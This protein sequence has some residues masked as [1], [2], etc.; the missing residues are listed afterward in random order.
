MFYEQDT[1]GQILSLARITTPGRLRAGLSYLMEAHGFRHYVFTWR[2]QS[3][4]GAGLFTLHNLSLNPISPDW[5]VDTD[6]LARYATQGAL[7]IDWRALM[8]R[9]DFQERAYRVTMRRRAALGL[10]AGCTVPLLNGPGEL[11]WLD[12]AMDRDD[13]QAWL[14]IR[15]YLP[16]ATL[17]GRVL[18]ERVGRFIADAAEPG[19]RPEEPLS[20]RERACLRGASEGLCNAEIGAA[21]GISERTVSSHIQRACHKLRARNRQHAITKALL[22]YQLYDRFFLP[23]PTTVPEQTA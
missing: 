23:A 3:L 19:E 13:D 18:L 5:P 21:L 15:T 12:L 6:P 8:M 17:L 22:S 14:H 1:A 11:A 9:A 7:P 2:G 16:C 10:R 4:G 20:D